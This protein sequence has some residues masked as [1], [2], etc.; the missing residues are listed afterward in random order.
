MSRILIIGDVHGCLKELKQ[1]LNIVKYNT[2]DRLIFLG[3]L[4]D[5]GPHSAECV[6]FV[7][8]KLKAE[9]VIG[10]HDNKYCRYYH[11]EK[12][13]KINPKYNNPMRFNE[14]QKEIYKN[15]DERDLDWLSNLPYKI[16]IKEHNLALMH[17]GVMDTTHPLYQNDKTYIYC[18][19]V[20]KLTGKMVRLNYDYSQPEN[21]VFW[22]TNYHYNVNIVYGH[23]V[24][25]LQNPKILT[26]DCGAK[27]YGID[28]GCVYGGHLTALI[29]KENGHTHYEQVKSSFKYKDFKLNKF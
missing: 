28:T 8:Q 12:R 10:N 9:C 1:L 24:V 25:D 29:I 17:A 7:R 11:H 4:V 18:R 22:A 13:R 14:N 21:S 2:N 3:D 19:Y 16:Y 5:R 26:N 15:L 27:T 20:D 6:K 23:Q